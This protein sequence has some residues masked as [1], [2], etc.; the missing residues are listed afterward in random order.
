MF[1]SVI[2]TGLSARRDSMLINGGGAAVLLAFAG[3]LVTQG[4]AR[5]VVGSL[6]SPLMWFLGGVLATA[7]ASGATYIAQRSWHGALN[8]RGKLFNGM[9]VVLVVSS[10]IT[11][12][13]ACKLGFDILRNL[14]R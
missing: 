8:L 10:Y 2:S 12:A 7:L 6:A 1:R 11:F 9:A 13:V 5:A 14:P 3:H 4:G